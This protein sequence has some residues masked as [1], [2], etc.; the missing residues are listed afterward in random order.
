[1]L[2]ES[3]ADIG[4]STKYVG[5]L[6]SVD[7]ERLCLSPAGRATT[8]AAYCQAS[9]TGARGSGPVVS[10]LLRHRSSAGADRRDVVQGRSRDT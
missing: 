4:Q 1:M 3:D 10:T 8:S 6:L 7:S 9:G 5:Y 2:G